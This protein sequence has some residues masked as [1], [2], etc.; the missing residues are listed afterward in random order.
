[1][2][3]VLEEL[4][5]GDDVTIAAREQF[6]ILRVASCQAVVVD[7]LVLLAAASH[8]VGIA[9]AQLQ[10]RLCDGLAVSGPVAFVVLVHV[11]DVL[12]LIVANH[13]ETTTFTD[14]TEVLH[15]GQRG[16][17]CGIDAAHGTFVVHELAVR[18]EVALHLCGIVHAHG[19]IHVGQVQV[20]PVDGD[21]VAGLAQHGLCHRA[22]FQVVDAAGADAF[23]AC[24]LIHLVDGQLGCGGKV[25]LYVVCLAV[26]RGDLIG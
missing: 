13:H 20:A 16:H 9:V 17:R 5:G 19:S 11:A 1:M 21:E 4:M 7:G 24:R 18:T 3:L 26:G 25:E 2:V 8:D 23:R 6:G 15:V 22:R 12:Y 10:E 14:F